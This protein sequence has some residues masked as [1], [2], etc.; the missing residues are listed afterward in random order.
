MSCRGSNDQIIQAL[1]FLTIYLV[2]KRWYVLGGFFF[3][4]SIHFKIY[5]IIFSF[6]L[7][8]FIDCDRDLIA[9]GGNPYQA[10]ISKKGFFTWNRV[11]FTVMTV[12]TLVGL[13]G[14]FYYLYGYEFLYESILYHFIRKDNRHNNSAYWYLSYQLFDEE[15]SLL[16]SLL[17]AAP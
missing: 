10:I 9:K 14:L 8:F 4:L 3:G 11:V 12:G 5:P 6:V 17:T 7:Y 1:V 15:K 16:M 2:L 13:T